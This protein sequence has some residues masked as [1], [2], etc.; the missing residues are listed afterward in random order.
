M[1]NYRKAIELTDDAKFEQ[2]ARGDARKRL[3]ALGVP[4]QPAALAK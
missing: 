4:E 3:A 1:P 2:Y